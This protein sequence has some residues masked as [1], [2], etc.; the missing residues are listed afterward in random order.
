MKKL[1]KVKTDLISP[2]LINVSGKIYEVMKYKVDN[3][4]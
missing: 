4:W 1:E 2:I 3:L